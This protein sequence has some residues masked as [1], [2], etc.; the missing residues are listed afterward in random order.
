DAETRL[1]PAAGSIYFGGSSGSKGTGGTVRPSTPE[2][3]EPKI[4][5]ALAKLSSEDRPLAEAQRFCVGLKD[6]RLGSMGPPLKLTFDGR[7][8]FPCAEG[9]KPKALED[10]KGM[11]AK[12][13]DLRNKQPGTTA[14]GARPSS[15][16]ERT[17]DEA[18][19]E[20][21]LAK[22]SPADRERAEQQKF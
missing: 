6:S 13:R 12:A 15:V 7:T 1:N 11:A 10:P 19:I 2:D 9:C 8:V 4:T 3:S 17:A 18:K 20:A 16:P 21:A 14:E 5:G 22:L